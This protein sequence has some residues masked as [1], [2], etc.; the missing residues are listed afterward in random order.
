M[1]TG[2]SAALAC[3]SRLAQSW[4]PA[5]TRTT[6]LGIA[7]ITCSRCGGMLSNVLLGT[8]L[9]GLCGLKWRTALF[10]FA[11]GGLAFGM[12]FAFLFRN[13]PREHPWANDAEAELIGQPATPLPRMTMWQLLASIRPAAA[14][15]F[16]AL[17]LQTVLSTFADNIYSNWIPLFL[18]QVYQSSDTKGGLLSAL[19]LFGG[20]LSGAAGGLLND[21]CIAWTGN[22][23]WSRVTIAIVGKGLAA[24]LLAVALIWYRNP[25]VFCWFLFAVKFF[26]D[27]SLTTSWGVVTDIGGRTTASVFAFNNTIAGL[28]LIAA[29]PIFGYIARHHGWPPVFV[30]VAVTYVLCALS[31]LAIDCTQPLMSE[32]QIAKP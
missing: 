14:P 22:R 18:M 25:Y 13:S 5:T 29:S 27:W 11:G 17:N 19:P 12:L 3:L 20:T 8:V 7:A 21:A 26:G 6:L 24:V 30:T 32:P 10:I 16:F 2:Q 31:W 4:F 1:G 15:S 23:R 28:A 9:L